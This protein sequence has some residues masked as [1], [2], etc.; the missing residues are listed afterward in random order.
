M[1]IKIPICALLTV[2]Y[3]AGQFTIPA[4]KPSAPVFSVPDTLIQMERTLCY[5][6]CP[7]Y[8]LTIYGSGK[9]V[10]EGKEFTAHKGTAE[11]EM[12]R[13]KLSKLLRLIKEIN[14]MQIPSNPECESRMTDHPS[15]FLTVE[16]GNERNNI[17]HY[18]GCKGF[19]HEEELYKLETAIDSLSGAKRWIGKGS[20]NFE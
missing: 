16:I 7:A 14:F 12:S 13:E 4:V 10:F 1:Y 5:G 15:V 9:V 19:E 8:E 2:F 20:F 18:L 6:T 3:L 17:T 11:G